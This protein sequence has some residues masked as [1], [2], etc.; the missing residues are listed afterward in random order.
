MQLV[1]CGMHCGQTLTVANDG[2]VDNE[3]Q[4]GQLVGGSIRSIEQCC[5]VVVA[6]ARIVGSSSSGGA[7]DGS[8]NGKSLEE[9]DE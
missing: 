5:R 9:H 1:E 2:S 3:R 4:D 6:D 7:S 8:R